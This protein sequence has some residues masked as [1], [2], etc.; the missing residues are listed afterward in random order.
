[1]EDPTTTTQTPP[2]VDSGAT[3]STVDA[4]DDVAGL[5]AELERLSAQNADLKASR[6]ATKKKER[7][8]QAL[9][10]QRLEEQGKLKEA[11]DAKTAM[12][13]D[14]EARA[15]RTDELEAA[16]AEQMKQ[17]TEGVDEDFLKA[18]EP[19]PAL[20]KLAVLRKH[21][22]QAAATPQRSVPA[23]SGPSYTPAGDPLKIADKDRR[24]EA[25]NKMP[26]RDRGNKFLEILRGK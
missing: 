5:K 20:N 11:L 18:I 15:N 25:I 3:S 19:L 23:G 24:Q 14:L 6:D 13:A 2:P 4:G 1:M 7:E 22:T 12:I 8:T 17:L 9:H 21:N 16:F 26:A 10:A